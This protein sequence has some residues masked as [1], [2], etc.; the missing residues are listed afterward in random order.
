MIWTLLSL[1][2]I[3]DSKTTVHFDNMLIIQYHA[4][5]IT[6]QVYDQS[7]SQ[8]C[9]TLYQTYLCNLIGGYETRGIGARISDIGNLQEAS[10]TRTTGL[11]SMC[12]TNSPPNYKVEDTTQYP[13]KLH[14]A[15]KTTRYHTNSAQIPPIHRTPA[16]VVYIAL[17]LPTFRKQ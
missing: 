16:A 4:Q 12:L 8:R 11:I 14:H 9:W 15:P 3:P 6:T 7:S 2:P 1:D 17:S 13:A 5:E 10:T